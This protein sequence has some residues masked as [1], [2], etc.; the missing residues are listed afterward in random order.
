[1]RHLRSPIFGAHSKA[2]K[3]TRLI[4]SMLVLSYTGTGSFAEAEKQFKAVLER[5]R[6]DREAK[7]ML[8]RCQQHPPATPDVS[9]E[10]NGSGTSER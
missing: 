4:A 1:M 8:A 10:N 2:T 7:A 3:P 6:D 9:A 5:N